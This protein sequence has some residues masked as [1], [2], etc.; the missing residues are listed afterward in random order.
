MVMEDMNL[1]KR[2]F[3]AGSA[4]FR[5]ALSPRP[6]NLDGLVRA[7]V[8]LTPEAVGEGAHWSE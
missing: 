4:L 7:G 3:A 6:E 5:G 2:L 1:S 8:T